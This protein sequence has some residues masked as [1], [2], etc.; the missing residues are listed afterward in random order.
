MV[1]NDTSPQVNSSQPQNG[2][3]NPQSPSPFRSTT[4]TLNPELVVKPDIFTLYVG[5]LGSRMW[6]KH[7]SSDLSA[8]LQGL[9]VLSNRT[10]TRE[11]IDALTVHSSRR[12]YYDGLGFSTG[13]A[14]T[15]GILYRDARKSPYFPRRA[16]PIELVRNFY[17]FALHD[18]AGLGR[19][20][21]SG[22]VKGLAWMT[23]SA[24]LYHG[25]GM[26]T[27][28]GG[29][30]G[31]PCLKD[32]FDNLNRSN[33]E[34]VRK[35]KLQVTNERLQRKHDGRG[36]F[37]I[38]F[39]DASDQGGAY[40]DIEQ[41]QSSYGAS[42]ASDSPSYD[43]SYSTNTSEQYSGLAG[44]QPSVGSVSRNPQTYSNAEHEI[45]ASQPIFGADLLSGSSYDDASPTAAEYRNTAD[46]DGAPAG[47]SWARIRQQNAPGSGSRAQWG[48]SQPPTPAD[49][50]YGSASGEQ[51][52]YSYDKTRDKEQAQADFDR[53]MEAERNAST[54]ESPKSKGWWS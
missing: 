23:A 10:L 18:R 24:M 4:L 44:Q 25:L 20:M 52:R 43:T 32:I 3:R 19:A 50:A 46:T 29:I 48:R 15:T 17:S 13:A 34:E 26:W 22:A 21:F 1:L 53:M 39:P 40:G 38:Q 14:L 28:A 41:G 11:Q 2:S 5:F 42:P 45:P 49:S 8:S 30:A 54:D 12:T 47:N 7:V 37:V 36:P 9:W 6:K 51:D 33:P 27:H 31:D 16:S 35:R